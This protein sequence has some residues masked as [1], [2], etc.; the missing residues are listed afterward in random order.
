MAGQAYLLALHK[1]QN[2][3]DRVR[4]H[5]GVRSAAMEQ[6]IHCDG[7]K[8]WSG[9]S[10]PSPQEWHKHEAV[11]FSGALFLGFL[12]LFFVSLCFTNTELM[13]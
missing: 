10:I 1:I 7:S 12:F 4:L 9:S 2:Q 13:C 3:P 8:H 6:K 11:S 5:A